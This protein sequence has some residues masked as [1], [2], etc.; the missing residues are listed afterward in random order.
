MSPHNVDTNTHTQRQTDRHTD[1]DVCTTGQD[2]DRKQFDVTS[3]GLT[4]SSDTTLQQTTRGSSQNSTDFPPL[5]YS[6]RFIK[7]SIYSLAR[8]A[9]HAE[10]LMFCGATLFRHLPNG[11]L[12]ETNY[13]RIY[14]TGLLRIFKI[15]T[16]MGGYDQSDLVFTIVQGML[17]W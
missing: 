1:G 14:W 15:G 5:A 6:A 9:S 7:Y 10:A 2:G 13:L 17:S 16:H 11:P 4:R 12:L 3:S 8:P